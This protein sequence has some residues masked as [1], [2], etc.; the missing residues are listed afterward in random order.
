MTAE[1]DLFDVEL[2]TNNFLQQNMTQITGAT[3]PSDPTNEAQYLA[4]NM[5]AR[6]PQTSM[7]TDPGGQ[8][9]PPPPAAAMAEAGSEG[10]TP[11]RNARPRASPPA[12]EILDGRFKGR[13]HYLSLLKSF[14]GVREFLS[15]IIRSHS[16]LGAAKWDNASPQRRRSLP[17]YSASEAEHAMSEL[18][19]PKQLRRRYLGSYFDHFMGSYDI[20][21]TTRFWRDYTSFCQDAHP[22]GWSGHFVAL[23][24]C[25]MSCA[26]CLPEEASSFDGESS[27][28]R[29]EAVRWIDAV[30]QW[31]RSRMTEGTTLETF[32]IKC[33]VQI[34]KTANDIDSDGA[35]TASQTLI[36]DAISCGL[37]RDWELSGATGSAS[38][39]DL[40]RRMWAAVADLDIAQCIGRGVPSVA[41]DLF[42]DAREMPKLSQD[43][44]NG[45]QSRRQSNLTDTDGLLTQLS[46]SIRLLRYEIVGLVNDP[47]KH[48]SLHKTRLAAFRQR[49]HDALLSVTAFTNTGGEASKAKSTT[50][51]RA[52]LSL[53]LHE[54]LI[55]LHWPF[56]LVNDKNASLDREYFAFVCIRSS[57]AIV[58]I[59]EQMSECGLSQMALPASTLL[60][61]G[62]CLSLIQTEGTDNG[63]LQR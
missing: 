48:G 44:A 52:T 46:T 11:A 59:Y 62:F 26:R 42:T 1:E 60:R 17:T 29:N 47:D 25:M 45:S 3:N 61:A 12:M 55:L 22:R 51:T 9:V 36:A 18:L 39:Q 13:S 15:D 10:P 58:K 14:Q 23:L 43:C 38:G 49:I 63:R 35:Y 2:W 19:P 6:I 21:D 57:S 41:A 56:A 7:G 20:V 24:L 5:Q 50:I 31:L 16:I 28:A 32:Q 40:R 33:L 8:I 34:A 54:L 37:H 53:C 4:D 30:E 27:T